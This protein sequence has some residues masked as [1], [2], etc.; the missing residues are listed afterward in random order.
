VSAF[1]EREDSIYLK[2]SGS[3]SHLIVLWSGGVP[4]GFICRV[5]SFG[6]KSGVFLDVHLSVLLGAEAAK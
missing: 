5:I 2:I 1:L 4:C 3:K 6:S